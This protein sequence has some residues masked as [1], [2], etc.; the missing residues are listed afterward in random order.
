MKRGEYSYLCCL[1]RMGEFYDYDQLDYYLRTIKDNNLDMNEGMQFLDMQTRTEYATG[2]ERDPSID[3][4]LL[5]F[6]M[7]K[8]FNG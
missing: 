4:Y 6:L 2:I 7:E 1:Y 3:S 8:G 5:K